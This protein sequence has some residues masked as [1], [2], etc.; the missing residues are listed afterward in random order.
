MPSFLSSPGLIVIFGAT[1]GI[2]RAVAREL[3]RRGHALALV[4]R[5]AE[6]LEAE[7]ADLAIR[8]GQRPLVFEW[9]VLDRANH[10]RRFAGL[11]E[12]A[13]PAGGIAGVFFAPGTLP[14]EHGKDLDAGTVRH[15]FDLNLVEPVVVLG[16][17]ARHFRDRGAGWIS[18]VSS[19][20]GDRGRAPNR[21]YGA[22]KAGLSTWLEGLRATLHGTGVLVQ[23]V[24]PGP[25]RTPMTEGY[26]GPG[27][28]LAKPERVARD[29]VR[30]L[31][32][33]RTTVYT[34][35]YWRWV[36]VVIRMLPEALARRI[37]G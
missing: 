8:S 33:R 11:V 20:A 4:G 26:Q 18:A 34:P 15:T 30:G 10:D 25:V 29:I 17:F 31:S 2:A 37:R 5:H 6:A 9:D 16:L 22:S 1:S 36:M 32:R 27:V 7:A 24:K 13:G 12:I 23:T 28:L 35:G 14:D 3:A 21:T 19:V